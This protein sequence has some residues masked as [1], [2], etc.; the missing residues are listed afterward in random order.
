MSMAEVASASAPARCIGV[1]LIPSPYIARARIQAAVLD[2][3]HAASNDG[4]V[5]QLNLAA[6]TADIDATATYGIS[7]DRVAIGDRA[8]GQ[9]CL[10]RAR[11]G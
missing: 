10:N 7:T 2:C 9:S 3:T 5:T 4:C 11:C 1:G 6:A 8:L